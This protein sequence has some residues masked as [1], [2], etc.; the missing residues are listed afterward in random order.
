MPKGKG[1]VIDIGELTQSRAK[2]ALN[3]RSI[4]KYIPSEGFSFAID[5]PMVTAKILSINKTEV[6]KDG[7]DE[8]VSGSVRRTA[9]TTAL[10]HSALTIRSS[11]R[12]LDVLH[13]DCFRRHC[14][15]PG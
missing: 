12:S 14:N 15:H 7:V 11:G 10:R 3:C 2:R 6:S 8:Y 13:V 5:V 9:N 4:C 1:I